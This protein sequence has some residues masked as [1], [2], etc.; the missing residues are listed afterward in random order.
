MCAEVHA[1]T[2][3]PDTLS[4]GA[5]ALTDEP[6]AV[7]SEY[8]IMV[9][10]WNAMYTCSDEMP[11]LNQTLSLWKINWNVMLDGVYNLRC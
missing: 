9:F 7:D 5:R 1:L 4:D 8:S 6:D 11:Y 2:D 3:E 10:F